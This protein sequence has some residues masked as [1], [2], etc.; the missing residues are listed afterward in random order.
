MKA[1]ILGLAVA[2]SGCGSEFSSQGSGGAGGSVTPT[3]GAMG[4]AEILL[5]PPNLSVPNIGT[6]TNCTAGSTG[7]YS[8][9]LGAKGAPAPDR[10]R[11]SMLPSGPDFSVS[12]SVHSDGTTLRVRLAL[13]GTDANSRSVPVRLELAGAIPIA[14]G[15]EALEQG[16]FYSDDTGQLTTDPFAA[17]CVMENVTS[18]EP[19]SLSADFSCPVLVGTDAISGC[20]ASGSVALSGCSG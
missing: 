2:V 19:G 15:W 20:H 18:T 17:V 16:D 6:R 5:R 3:P 9:F 8:Y 13:E 1:V 11:S 14:S 4:A 10:V 12:C 7:T